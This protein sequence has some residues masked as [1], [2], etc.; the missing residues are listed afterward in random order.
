MEVETPNDMT[1]GFSALLQVPTLQEIAEAHPE[2]I[3][4][5]RSLDP[6]LT[7]AA[8]ASL[9]TLPELQS[10][11]F[12]IQALVHLALLF[13]K[14]ND[15]PSREFVAQQFDR[16]GRG[17]CGRMED[18]AEDVFVSRVH[19]SNG[20]FL[21]HEGLMEGA[22][23]YLQR[24]LEIVEGMP[25]R[26]PFDRTARAVSAML[27][28]ANEVA[29]RSD[30]REV[31]LGAEAPLD[32]I[33]LETVEKLA[34]L[35]E[36][37]QFTTT[38]LTQLGVNADDLADFLFDRRERESLTAQSMN[39]TAL[40]RRP[41]VRRD[42]T[43]YF[44]LPTETA[45]AI[46]RFVIETVQAAGQSGALE[47]VFAKEYSKLLSSNRVLG[48]R[49]DDYVAFEKTSIGHVASMMTEFDAGRFLHLIFVVD[50]LEGFSEDGLGG[51][52][53]DPETLGSIVSER[54][55]T[56][57]A[58]AS[59]QPGFRG[60]LSLIVSCGFGRGFAIELE[61]RPQRAWRTE[62]IS[63]YDL[64]T[65]NWL[66]EFDALSLWR[67]LNGREALKRQ[68]V[69]L[70]NVNGL[71]NLVAWAR[72]L[73]GHLVPH[74][75]LPEGFGSGEARSM[76]LVPQAAIRGLRYHVQTVWDTRR[77]QDRDG[78]W[79]KAFKLDHSAFEEDRAAPLFGSEDDARRKKLRA[80]YL[81]GKRSWWIGISAPEDSPSDGVF[82][83]W[84]ML[85]VW[86]KRLA[87]VLDSAYVDLPPGPLTIEVEFAEIVGT[88]KRPVKT[89]DLDTLRSLFQ[90]STDAGNLSIQ[91]GVGPGFD[92]GLCR[93]ENFAERALV[94]AIVKAVALLAGEA[95]DLA[96]QQRAVTRICPDTEGRSMH[97]F[98][99]R[100][101]RDHV[102]ANGAPDPVVIDKMDDATSRIGLGWK[103]WA[104]ESGS[105][106]VGVAEC[107]SVLNKV[108]KVE[109][110]ELC[111]LLRGLD[112]KSL[113][114]ATLENHEAAAIDAD[115]WK[116]TSRAN[117][118][119]HDNK[120]ATVQTLAEHQGRLNAVFLA[121]RLVLEAGVSECPVTG[122][123][124]VGHLDLS[125][126]MCHAVRAHQMGGW[127]DAIRWGAME[128]RVRITP[129]GDIFV[130]HDFI[131]KVYQPF[132]QEKGKA[133]VHEAAAQY[134]K[135]HQPQ[136][137]VPTVVGIFE[138]QFLEAWEAEFGSSLDG[139][140]RFV[141]ALEETGP[142][143]APFSL[144]RRSELVAILAK[145]SNITAE[146][147]ATTFELLS[148]MPRSQWRVVQGKFNDKDWFPWRFR[149]RLSVLRRP[150]L[151]LDESSHPEMLYAP[152]I[153]RDAL[154]LT[155]QAYHAGEVPSPH[156]ESSEM[157]KWVGQS[158]N[159][160][161]SKLNSEVADRMK[162][163]GWHVE[164]EVKPKH[165]LGRPLDRD[166][167]DV[168]VLAW[169]PDSERVLAIECKDLLF[170]KTL[171]QIAEQLS[172]F[173]GEVRADGKRDLLRK[174]LDRLDILNANKLDI[175]KKLKLPVLPQV[176]GHLV[177]RNPVPMRYA[178]ERMASKVRLSLFDELNR[179]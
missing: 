38:D 171:G 3:E 85:G 109:L 21:I 78:R 61:R 164:K 156:C 166:Y 100:S 55:R 16:L 175:Q 172:D 71:P 120:E 176:E 125:K 58:D 29:K 126:A 11:C 17:I 80:V 10:N 127:S 69:T 8:F 121:T 41:I 117:L 18:P 101:F 115:I 87:P 89:P 131:D 107:T 56:S 82:E 76:V 161:R 7:A 110:D 168:D 35:I 122:G 57:A 65:L 27:V 91:I 93:P 178:W 99:A 160:H 36:R 148:L 140:R 26:P 49:L 158:N 54:I 138:P 108:V 2:V 129:L 136:K 124:P 28:L 123:L 179:L 141:D 62:S 98:E 75:Q 45:T 51:M 144:R 112:R 53:A 154:R 67:L 22:G 97:R 79:L 146:Q 145:T 157:K 20:N 167:G 52:N 74:G 81:T 139:M 4:D 153:I 132:G 46:I 104:R 86:L 13:G 42:D 1:E 142:Q 12:R 152:G 165:I 83:H 90:I 84:K 118:A 111:S 103:V 102:R 14:G 170:N 73:D 150:F 6:V 169:R 135:L 33:Q 48:L 72:E 64:L 177:F 92:D 143:A 151:Q 88:T 32:H 162:E 23:F 60:G 159:L 96:K 77:V 174:H 68:G 133:D 50:G 113:L 15:A 94:E 39:H 66:P 106:I 116:R 44:L 59:K 119:L 134:G 155:L 173:L 5:I 37:I 34:R 24:F 114:T 130:N 137:V 95:V 40:S 105:E 63:V 19:N 147:A 25:K 9:L 43:L 31:V 163:L 30:T 149:R 128:P 70:V 47:A